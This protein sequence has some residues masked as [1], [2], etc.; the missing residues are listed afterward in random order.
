MSES[1]MK[2]LL[3]KTIK[4]VQE[5][6]QEITSVNTISLLQEMANVD[7]NIRKG[8]TDAIQARLDEFSPGVV[9]VT[10]NA[11]APPPER[12]ARGGA[13]TRAVTP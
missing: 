10:T 9:E 8:V 5:R 2:E 7:P 4:V 12:P 1:D 13:R 3:G 6:L 11:P